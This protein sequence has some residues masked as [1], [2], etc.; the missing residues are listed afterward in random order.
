[1]LDAP[2]DVDEVGLVV[3]VCWLALAPLV[4][5]CEPLPMLTPGLTSAPMLALELFTSTF[6]STPTFG[7]TLSDLELVLDEELGLVLDEELGFVLDDEELGLVLDRDDEL[8]DALGLVD[9]ELEELGDADD[10]PTLMSVELELVLG[11]VD[12]APPLRFRL[13][14][15]EELAGAWEEPLPLRFRFVELELDGVLELPGAM[16]TS[17]EVEEVPDVPARPGFTLIELEP[18]PGRTATPGVVT[19]VVVLL[20]D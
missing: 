2:C 9:E 12:E 5:L 19:S 11:L 14:E 6:A 18:A 3:D 8:P 10:L 4:T 7:L 17:V 20:L 1:M 15:L 13:L 16:F